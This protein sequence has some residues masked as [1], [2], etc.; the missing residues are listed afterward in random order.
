MKQILILILLSTAS[1]CFAQIDDNGNPVF[2]SVFTSEDTFKNY[3][4]IANYYT[5]KNNIDNK[6][7][8][9]YISAVPSINENLNAATNLPSDFFI[10]N[11]DQGMVRMAILLNQPKFL[12]I[13]IDPA[14]GKQSEYTCSIKG[15]I[16]ENRAK[17]LIREKFDPDGKIVGNLLYFNEKTLKIIA[18]KTIKDSLVVLIEKEQLYTPTATPQ[19]KIRTQAEIKTHILQESKEDGELDFFTEIK[20]KEYEGIFVKPKV[21]ATRQGMAFYKWGKACY[22][23]G[24]E[25]VDD[26]L[27]IY[28]EFKGRALNQR[29][30]D[31]IKMGFNLEL[32]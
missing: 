26:T 6:R 4:L 1:H 22:D 18:N 9:V 15:D 24:I 21:M 31:Y 3:H 28:A 19:V 2:N 17:E 25:S 30:K 27:S 7:S 12:F 8:S 10:I 11:N 16:T 14:T 29:E 32:E 13:V 23:L 20:G 5:L